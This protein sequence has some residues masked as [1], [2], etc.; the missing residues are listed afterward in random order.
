MRKK[1]KKTAIAAAVL[2]LFV[3]PILYII[4]RG[5]RETPAPAEEV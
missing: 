2:T 5:R 4:I 3:V 1:F